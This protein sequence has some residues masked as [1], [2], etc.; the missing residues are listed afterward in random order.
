MKKYR[1]CLYSDS[2]SIIKIFHILLSNKQ[3]VMSLSK[4]FFKSFATLSSSPL[5]LRQVVHAA[6]MLITV[7]GADTILLF[8]TFFR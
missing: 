7:E 8:N 1:G 5:V 6:F 3:R 2:K 4:H